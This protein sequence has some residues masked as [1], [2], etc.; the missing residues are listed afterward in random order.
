MRRSWRST[1][2]AIAA[3]RR[4]KPGQAASDHRQCGLLSEPAQNLALWPPRLEVGCRD[5]CDSSRGFVPPV[6]QALSRGSVFIAEI[7][8]AI[9]AAGNPG[10][11]PASSPSASNQ[12]ALVKMQ[13]AARSN[14]ALTS[15]DDPAG[16][17][18][19]LLLQSASTDF[20]FCSPRGGL[21]CFPCRCCTGRRSSSTCSDPRGPPLKAAWAQSR[22][23]HRRRPYVRRCY[24][25][26]PGGSGQDH[27]W[28]CQVV[29][30][31]G[32]PPRA[33]RQSS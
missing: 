25:G 13:T 33:R 4:R 23:V 8:A 32:R 30:G 12:A 19:V 10:H 24:V 7:V 3:G 16:A 29:G 18:P 11:H 17:A 22:D 6:I 27:T 5:P 14:S 31:E 21:V 2:R 15:L 9:V 20:D 26:P 1:P 28:A